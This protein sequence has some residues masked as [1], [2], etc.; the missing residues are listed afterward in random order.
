MTGKTAPLQRE[1]DGLHYANYTGTGNTFNANHPIVRR[2]IVGSLRYCVEV[3]HE[4]GFRFDLASILAWDAPGH[5]AAGY[6]YD[7]H[8]QRRAAHPAWQQRCLL[9]MALMAQEHKPYPF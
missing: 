8:G 4:D 1:P 2:L 3:M 7:T 6:A 5:L 9:P